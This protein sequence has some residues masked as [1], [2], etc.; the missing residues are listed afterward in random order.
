MPRISASR[1]NPSVN[2]G[3]SIDNLPQRT[4]N[5]LEHGAPEGERNHELFE[6]ACQFRDA[7]FTQDDASGY[8]GPRAEKDG[9][10]QAE[11]L[12]TIRSAYNR[13]PPGIDLWQEW[14]NSARLGR[15]T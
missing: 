10:S 2:A 4:R 5:Y 12:C 11:I 1:F 8:L 15:F 9:L 6:A 7:G 3:P 13:S 14:R